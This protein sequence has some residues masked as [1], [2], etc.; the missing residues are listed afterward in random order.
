V[1]DDIDN[2]VWSELESAVQDS[3]RVGSLDDGDVTWS[4]LSNDVQDSVQTVKLQVYNNIRTLGETELGEM[5]LEQDTTGNLI[6]IGRTVPRVYK[7]Q[8]FSSTKIDSFD[9]PYTSP[10]GCTVDTLGNL[11]IVDDVEHHVYKFDGF[12][13]T[14]LDSFD[15]DYLLWGTA[16]GTT[17]VQDK[18]YIV[19]NDSLRIGIYDLG[20]VGGNYGDSLDTK[21][22][23]DD[24]AGG[25]PDSLFWLFSAPHSTS[26]IM[27]E[28]GLYT[29]PPDSGIGHYARSGG[30]W[31]DCWSEGFCNV[32]YYVEYT[33]LNIISVGYNVI[34]KDWISESIKIYKSEGEVPIGV[35]DSLDLPDSNFGGI[36]WDNYLQRT[37]QL[38]AD[39]I[40]KVRILN[41][42]K[43]IRFED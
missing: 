9:Y 32:A 42:I 28:G 36:C 37:D 14:V 1:Q 43:A 11:H 20:Y 22:A 3:I 18:I 19:Y 10:R 4:K 5:W 21:I 16:W 40:V 35:L 15:T 25:R 2:V 6:Y 30:A 27:A 31:G 26:P 24:D 17:C 13:S 33:G 41:E 38:E 39:Y 34:W 23:C 12:S 8:G 7:L 29:D